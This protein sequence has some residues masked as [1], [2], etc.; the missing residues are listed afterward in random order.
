MSDAVV[1]NY[2]LSGW[3]RQP[4]DP[5]DWKFS[6]PRRLLA[7]LPAAIDLSANMPENFDQGN[8]GSC[9]PATARAGIQYE[10]KAEDFA[11]LTPSVLFMYFNARRLMGTIGYDSGVDNRS[12][13]KSLAQY[14]Y[15][16]EASY[17]YIPNRFTQTPPASCY[18]EALPNKIVSYAAVPQTLDDMRACLASGYPFIFGFRVYASMLTNEVARTGIIPMPRSSDVLKGGHD[19]LVIGY[20]DAKQSFKFRNHWRN[21]DGSWWGQGGN[22][23]IPYAYATNRELAGD[24]WC[25]NAVPGTIVKPVPDPAPA[26]TPAPTPANNKIVIDLDNKSVSVPP[27]WARQ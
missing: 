19:V 11:S 23:W 24:F 15:C 7:S 22:G 9:G 12:L 10:R 18:T 14:G 1:G 5:R 2:N 4:E 16:S 20:D 27:G 13:V 21:G 6:A 25:L 26:P 17:P 8:L 3:I